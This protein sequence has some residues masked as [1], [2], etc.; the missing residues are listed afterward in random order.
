MQGLAGVYEIRAI[1]CRSDGVLYVCFA[2]TLWAGS[3]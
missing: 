1:H 3:S 2:F